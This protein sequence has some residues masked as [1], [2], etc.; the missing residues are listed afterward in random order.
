LVDL[1]AI[2]HRAHRKLDPRG[3]DLAVVDVFVVRID[4][5]A[6]QLSIRSKIPMAPGPFLKE[7]VGERTDLQRDVE[8]VGVV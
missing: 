7:L 2:S 5:C 4:F 1:Q 3:R 6:D 8:Q